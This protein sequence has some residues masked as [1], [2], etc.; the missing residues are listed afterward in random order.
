MHASL[1]VVL[2]TDALLEV[3][4]LMVSHRAFFR[5]LISRASPLARQARMSRFV[6][7]MKVKPHQRVLDLGGLPKLW[8][9]VDIPL[10]ITVLNLPSQII[11]ERTYN[12]HSFTIMRGD[13]TNLSH[14]PDNSY[15]IVFSNSVIEHVGPQEKQAAFA[16]EARRVGSSYYIQTPSI[17]FPLEAH[18]GLPF[19]WYYPEWVRNKIIAR[20][21]RSTPDYAK[22][23]QGTRVLGK[24][25]LRRFFPDGTIETE[26][27]FGFV[28]S[29]TVWRT[30]DCFRS[31]SLN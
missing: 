25:D 13:A 2:R 19:W 31:A 30:S 22:F 3:K 26:R 5:T 1:A 16:A 11:D 4:V 23:V 6:E 21:K 15:D 12:A 17:H 24:P 20:W 27:V 18:T 14:V 7:L 10:D 28:K 29:Y 9:F 8:R